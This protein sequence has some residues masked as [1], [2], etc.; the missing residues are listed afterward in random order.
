MGVAFAEAGS[1]AR[2]RAGHRHARLWLKPH[3]EELLLGLVHAD[4][5]ARNIALSHH[6]RYDGKGYPNGLADGAIPLEARV[7]ALADVYDALT[8]KRC[9]KEAFPVAEAERIIRE[10][11]GRHFDP[12]TV[13]GLFA[14]IE[15]FHAIRGRYKDA[16]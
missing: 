11:R 6:E 14:A 16:E 7:V 9:Y 3:A 1:A 10:E 12:G 15:D 2:V 13:D 8:T 5:M 4:D